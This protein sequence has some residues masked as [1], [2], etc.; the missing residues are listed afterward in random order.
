MLLM[1]LIVTAL[2]PGAAV[3]ALTCVVR[4]VAAG[5]GPVLGGLV[6]AA[7]WPVVVPAWRELTGREPG[8]VLRLPG[9]VWL[10]VAGTVGCLV[11]F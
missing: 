6:L 1:F 5:W 7:T 10:G 8:R 2:V 11:L 9:W 4:A 3:L